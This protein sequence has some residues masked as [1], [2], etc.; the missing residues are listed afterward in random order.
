MQ[1]AGKQAAEN[2]LFNPKA[3][4][5]GPGRTGFNPLTEKNAENGTDTQTRHGRKIYVGNLPE[6]ATSGGVREFF[7]K[8]INTILTA[9]LPGDA[10]VGCYLN[11]QRRFCFLELRTLREAEFLLNF[12]GIFYAGNAL[13]LR[14]PQDFNAVIFPQQMEAEKKQFQQEHP[15]LAAKYEKSPSPE[16]IAGA[17]GIL[18]S[19]VEDGPEKMFVGGLPMLMTDD[20][21]K[22]L[23]QSFGPLKGLHL[24][25]ER[26]NPN[27]S[28]GF[29]FVQWRSM[30]SADSAM[31]A[32]HG[33][34]FGQRNL[35]VRRAVDHE[36][37]RKMSV[38]NGTQATSQYMTPEQFK[39]TRVLSIFNM[40]PMIQTTDEAEVGRV[41]A[42]SREECQKIGDVLS[43]EWRDYQ[44]LVE[45]S[46]V[47]GAQAGMGMMQGRKY[48]GR[49]LCCAYAN[50]TE[51]MQQLG[52]S[53]WHC[54][55]PATP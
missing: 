2:L 12:D 55:L 47:E 6:D 16:I 50:P 53:C 11:A 21:L 49:V 19:T 37:Y 20:E 1:E 32:L 8:T 36:Q 7:N 51:K 18:S 25:K 52:T 22:Q 3:P 54:R 41:T 31:R 14:R 46:T 34:K 42:E 9:K 45:F 17:L 10:L 4:R 39:P 38:S 26:D 5:S 27:Q 48:D 23:L 13:R 44:V 29:A 43:A 35:T 33:M 28:K 15:E 40:L 24:I 30:C